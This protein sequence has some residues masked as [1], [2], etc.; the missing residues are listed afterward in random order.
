MS[1]SQLALHHI[2]SYYRNNAPKSNKFNIHIPDF[3]QNKPKT[4]SVDNV[5]IP[6]SYY[7]VN[8]NNNQFTIDFGT[9]SSQIILDNGNY[10]SI[11]ILDELN[12]KMTLQS[13]VTFTTSYSNQSGKLNYLGTTGYDFDIISN[14]F[15]F[16][17]LGFNKSS[18]NSSSGNQPSL[19]SSNVVNLIGTKY[20]DIVSNLGLTTSTNRDRDERQILARIPAVSSGPLNTIFFN[21]KTLEFVTY[22]YDHLSQLSLELRDDKN[23]LLDLN[24]QDWS[25]TLKV[26]IN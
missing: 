21:S 2:D 9:T 13:G 18:T 19:T 24:G 22:Q 17:Y 6:F 26:Q 8:D 4:I 12:E 16:E 3:F 25:M 14:G 1:N 10:N 11:T 5:A 20:I 15:N 7:A 23:N